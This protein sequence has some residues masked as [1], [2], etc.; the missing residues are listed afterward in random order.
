VLRPTLPAA[1]IVVAAAALATAEVSPSPADAKARLLALEDARRLDAPALNALVAHDSPGIRARTARAL[2]ATAD[3]RAA[4]LLARLGKDRDP[5]VRAAAAEGAGRLAGRVPGVNDAAAIKKVEALLRRLLGDPDAQ[6]RA[7]AAWGLGASGLAGGEA[8]LLGRFAS[9]RDPGVRAAILQELWRTKGARW[10]AVATAALADGEPRVRLAAAWSLSRSGS[11]DAVEGLVR[12]ARDGEPTVRLVALDGIRRGAFAE[13]WDAALAGIRDSDERVRVAALLALVPL[14]EARTNDPVPA[15]LGAALAPLLRDSDPRTVHRRVAGVRLA[16]AARCCREDLVAVV[17]AG[18]RWVSGEALEALARSGAPEASAL[19]ESW[20]D[21]DDDEARV[22]G[23]RAVA[24][25][26]DG[27][28][29]L[30]AH[31]T[32]PSAAVRLAAV[33]RL[34]ESADAAAVDALR[35]RLGDGDP[36]VRAAAVEALGRAAGNGV[37]GAALAPQALIEALARE[38]GAAVPDAAVALIDALSAGKTLPPAVARTLHGLKVSKDPVVARSAWAALA[39]HGTHSSLP[40][41]ATGNDLEFYRGVVAWAARERWIEI[42]TWRGTLQVRLDTV[43]A[44]LTCFRLAEL[45]EKKFFDGLTFH[46]V[47]P[48]FV[49]QGGDP[50]GDGWGG[51]GFTMR[52]ELSLS[53]FEAGAVGLAHAGPDTAGSQLFVTLTAQPHLTGRYP[54]IGTVVN[55][56]DVAER[57]RVGDRIIRVRAGE[58]PLPAYVPVWYG[59]VEAGRLDREIPHWRDEREAYVPKEEWLAHLRTAR[60]RYELHVAMGTWCGDSREQGPRLEKVLAALGSDSPFEAPRLTA[61]DRS[62]AIDAAAWPFGTIEL[63]P[64]IVVAAGGS[65]LGRIAETPS[66]G[67][68]EEDLAR[69]LAPIEGWQLPDPAPKE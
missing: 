1:L 2:A 65:E 54:V 67:S 57:L 41:V 30:V 17:G 58:G 28:S 42:V 26:P 3:P 32:D 64:T 44:P 49:A 47:V 25:L 38:D 7:A 15:S 31:L 51:P 35:G 59:P 68:L 56:L 16:G 39:R 50:R 22:A 21:R 8:A 63:V 69:I 5:S 46:R 6:V 60:L 18:E 27:V 53:P 13:G 40:E 61:I 45:T 66:S 19:V 20:L 34:G 48:E 10:A 11:K 29:R 23:V 37:P 52:D 36:A 43:H 33:E 55:G 24:L 4:G 12:A 14:A 9:E 62:K